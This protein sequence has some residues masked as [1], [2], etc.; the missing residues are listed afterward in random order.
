MGAPFLCPATGRNGDIFYVTRWNV[1]SVVNI[2]GRAEL[3]S[4]NCEVQLSADVV[5]GEFRYEL[6]AYP[7]VLGCCP[8]AACVL[9][10]WIKCVTSGQRRSKRDVD[11][12]EICDMSGGVDLP[13]A[14]RSDHS[15]FG[16]PAPLERTVGGPRLRFDWPNM[17]ISSD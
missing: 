1:T 7:S 14:A 11:T 4:S 2:E 16:S 3:P 8:A 5:V 9:S 6:R 13:M 12:F 17:G 10:F 15:P